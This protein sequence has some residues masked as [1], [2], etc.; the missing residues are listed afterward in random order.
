M[1]SAHYKLSC[2]FGFLMSYVF[3]M[4]NDEPRHSYEKIHH[5]ELYG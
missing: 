5:D 1:L 4:I 2:Q 3:E